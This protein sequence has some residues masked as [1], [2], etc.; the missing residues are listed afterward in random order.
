MVTETMIREKLLRLE[1]A[2]NEQLPDIAIQLREIH[3]A[4]SSSPEVV[5]LLT[6][7]ECAILVAG[8]KSY[9]SK[10]IIASTP[11]NRKALKDTTLDDL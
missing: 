11:K 9:T 3:T 6:P 5:S 4:L 2:L 8:L 7:A 1:A 10:A